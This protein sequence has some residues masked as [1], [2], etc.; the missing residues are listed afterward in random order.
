MTETW[1]YK[2][3]L[4]EKL[5]KKEAATPTYQSIAAAPAP[6]KLKPAKPKLSYKLQFELD[7]L[8]QK[9]AD[10]EAEIAELVKNLQDAGFYKRDPQAF[11]DSSV[12]LEK[13]KAEL[14][15]A[16]NRWLELESLQQAG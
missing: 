3:A 14:E 1:N 2:Q 5:D 4:L 9:M 10:L 8:P 7:N 6:E 11:Q 13:A 16:E 12:R 15:K